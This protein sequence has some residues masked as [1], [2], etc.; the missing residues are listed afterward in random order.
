MAVIKD[1]AREAGVSATTVSRYLNGGKYVKAEISERIRAAIE[2]LDYKPSHIARSLVSQRSRMLGVIVPDIRAGYHG[3][4]L[5]HIEATA[6]HNGYSI[7]MC[8]IAE[9]ARKELAYIDFLLNMPVDGIVILH[10]ELT[11]ETAALLNGTRIPIVF[12]GV[13]PIRGQYISVAIDD[14]RAA[15][16]G[17]AY[18]LDAGHRTVAFLGGHLKD[19]SSGQERLKGFRDA[20]R[21]RG[22]LPRE[23]LI[24]HGGYSYA[25][26]YR[27]AQEMLAIEGVRPTA[28]FCM[29]DEVAVGCLN[30]LT[31][32]KVAVPD[33]VAVMGFD[34]LSV[35]EQVRP[36][37]STLRQPLDEIGSMSVELLVDAIEKRQ[38]F[39][40]M[41]DL[42][43]PHH[44]EIRESVSIRPPERG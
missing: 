44:L 26:G 16:D 34:G 9:D 33:E 31:D 42:V 6:N 22:L 30:A 21:D 8:N 13:R 40:N 19:H 27:L 37:L 10:E 3:T 17:T 1:V 5:S 43:L 12:A 38:R 41:F 25:V 32:R 36:R 35:T 4:L 18:L 2:R 28:A 20:H 11:E 15:Y 29:S 23:E 14:C 39:P 7:L 24:L